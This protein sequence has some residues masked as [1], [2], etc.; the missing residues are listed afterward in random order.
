MHRGQITLRDWE[1]EKE[2]AIETE[3]EQPV[4]EE[5]QENRVPEVKWKKGFEDRSDQ[6]HQILLKVN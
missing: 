3:K 5:N 6:L 2:P 1:D 4:R